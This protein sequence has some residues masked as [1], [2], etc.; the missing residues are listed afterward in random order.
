MFARRLLR[1]LEGELPL[2]IDT[3][4]FDMVRI[5]E[6]LH[7]EKN[8]A[9]GPVAI[10]TVVRN[11][12]ERARHDYGLTGVRSM[13]LLAILMWFLGY[14]CDEDPFHPWIRDALTMH[15]SK[16][17]EAAGARLETRAV[18]FFEAYLQELA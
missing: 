9:A 5:F 17:T 10:E 18:A 3:F 11:A 6:E 16:G 4:E 7:P 8:H 14:R 1:M 12:M 15:E 2:H 13:A